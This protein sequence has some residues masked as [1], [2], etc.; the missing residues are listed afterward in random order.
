M[1]RGEQK[2]AWTFIAKATELH[3]VA[4][5]DQRRDREAVAERLA[6]D[7]QV[8][9]DSMERARAAVVPAEPV[10]IS[11]RMTQRAARATQRDER[12]QESRLR[13][14]DRFGLEHHGGNIVPAA[15]LNSASRLARSL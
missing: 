1:R 8:G 11:S 2:H 13:F 6:V 9:V 5:A 14:R 12:L 7:D 4:P 3:D 10:I 15:P